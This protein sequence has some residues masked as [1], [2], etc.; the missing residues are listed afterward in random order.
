MLIRM[1]IHMS[2]HMP[3]HT[4]VHR[5]GL[6]KSKG[7]LINADLGG[8]AIDPTTKVFLFAARYIKIDL[9]LPN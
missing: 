8:N 4:S 3:I 9:P 6:L 1:P 5:Y 2:I 7:C